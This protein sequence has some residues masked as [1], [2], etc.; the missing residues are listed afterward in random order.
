[1]KSVLIQL[2]VLL[3]FCS[4]QETKKSDKSPD[5]NKDSIEC[6]QEESKKMLLKAIISLPKLQQY[7]HPSEKGHEQ[8]IVQRHTY[9][10]SIELDSSSSQSKQ[11]WLA[12]ESGYARYSSSNYERLIKFE[13]LEEKGDTVFVEFRYESEGVICFTSLRNQNCNWIEIETDI[14]EE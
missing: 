11:F 4:C 7:I 9:F 13:R 12:Q 5:V 14:A 10:D 8:I 2:I 3:A 6:S 1:M